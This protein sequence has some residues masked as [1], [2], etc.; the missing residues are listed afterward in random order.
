MHKKLYIDWKKMF[1]VD[2][3][4]CVAQFESSNLKQLVLKICRGRYS[5][6]SQRY[7]NELRLLLN[8]LFKVSPRDR[9]S[10]NSLLKRPLLQPLISRH[11]DTQVGRHLLDYW[12]LKDTDRN[13][14]VFVFLT[15]T[16]N[17][18]EEASISKIQ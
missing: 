16:F 3:C 7:S 6:V 13:I 1:W 2:E 12:K 18:W 17:I 4:V 10:A 8:Q 14:S 9:P 11:L 5:P 15:T